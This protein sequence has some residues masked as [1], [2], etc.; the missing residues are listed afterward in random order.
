[1]QSHNLISALLVSFLMS[2][3]AAV[4]AQEPL[5]PVKLLTTASGDVLLERRFYGQVAAKQSVDLAFQVSGQILDF[6]VVQ[7]NIVPKGAQIAQLDL[8]QF[9]LQLDQAQ[10]QLGQSERTVARMKQLKGNVSQVAI[11]DAETQVGLANIAVRNAEYAL[12]HATLNAPFDALI[13][14]REV[15]IFSTVNPGMPIVRLHDMSELHIEVDVPEVLFQR[16][17]GE[18]DVVITASFPGRPGEIPLQILEFD[19]EASNVGQTFRVTFALLPPE[20]FQ[21]FPGASATVKVVMSTDENAIFLPSTAVI[22]N[23]Q[24]DLGVMV[25]EP[26]GAEQGTVNWTAVEVEPTQGGDFQVLSGLEGGQ[27][28]VL[29]GGNALKDDQAVSRF[30]GFAN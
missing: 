27:D 17:D 25:F 20:G 14:R 30:N 24:G 23:P 19:A 13:S 10:L 1:M 2:V 15:A 22:A 12:K 3:P 18:N 6:P 11:D 9:Q 16:T 28:V 5:K 8:E 21:V 29:T 26:T 4:S 7:G